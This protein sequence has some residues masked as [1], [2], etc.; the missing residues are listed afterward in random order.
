[1]TRRDW[2]A[3]SDAGFSRGI[4][5]WGRLYLISTPVPDRPDGK[6]EDDAGP[7][8][9]RPHDGSQEVHGVGRREVVGTRDVVGVV[10]EAV[11]YGI[12]VTCHQLVVPTHLTDCYREHHQ[13]TNYLLQ[14][15]RQLGRYGFRLSRWKSV[16]AL[17]SEGNST[18]YVEGYKWEENQEYWANLQAV[19]KRTCNIPKKWYLK[20][21]RAT[22]YLPLRVLVLSSINSLKIGK[23]SYMSSMNAQN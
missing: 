8:Q 11:G 22:K 20:K 13:N 19:W 1:M 4:I 23:G 2:I 17:L 18:G 3:G 9:V 14:Y 10:S 5:L 16:Y 15:I 21:E 12:E 7:G 6:T